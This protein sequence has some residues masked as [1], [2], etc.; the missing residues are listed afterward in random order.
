MGRR[1]DEPLKPARL[2]TAGGALR[3][4]A[5]SWNGRLFL[6]CGETLRFLSD[7]LGYDSTP[8]VPERSFIRGFVQPGRGG[9]FEILDQSGLFRRELAPLSQEE[10]DRLIL[11][12]LVWQL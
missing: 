6:E 4:K 2:T 7:V 8:Q 5:A 10:T 9:T 11:K 3:L 12:R 1:K